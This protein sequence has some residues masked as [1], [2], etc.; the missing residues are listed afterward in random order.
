MQLNYRLRTLKT[1][2]KK[3]PVILIHGLFGDLNNLRIIAES[4]AQHCYVVQVDLR[5]HGR[6]PHEQSMTYSIM[7][8]DILDLLEQ[9]SIKKCIIIGHSM[10]GKVAM[11]LCMLAP[12]RISKVIVIDIAPVKY[13]AHSHDDIFR[14][15]EYINNSGVKSRDEAV[16]LMQ[17]CSID[18]TLILFLLKS[19]RKGSWIFNFSS[20]KNNYIYINDWD[21]YQ[22][23]WG[24]ALFIKGALSSYLDDCYLHDIYHQ[25]PQA[26][27]QK[28]P[29]AGH[30]VHWDNSIHVLNIIH[31]FIIY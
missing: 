31:K 16:R 26:Y 7:A 1:I 15:I 2:Y 24:P 10:G 5:N 23:W 29:N 13:N 25:F 27:I 19:F 21:T 30:W 6:S 8:K 22:T 3:T 20:I 18:R 4:L 17:Q 28:I 11:K 9:L 14:A 12:Q